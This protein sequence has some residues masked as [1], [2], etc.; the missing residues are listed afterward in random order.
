[1]YEENLYKEKIIDLFLWEERKFFLSDTVCV[2][3]NK[4]NEL[5]GIHTILPIHYVHNN[6]IR[7]Y[8]RSEYLR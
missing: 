4:E 2:H 5:D 8:Q 1:M 7:A 3:Q 6:S